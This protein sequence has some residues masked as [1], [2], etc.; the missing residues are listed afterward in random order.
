MKLSALSVSETLRA[1]FFSSSFSSL[2]FKCLE[3]TNFPSLPKKGELLM[4][5]CIFIVGSS[6]LV[7]G[8]A[9]G[10]SKSAI[11]SPIL[12]P[13]IPTTAQMSPARTSVTFFFPSPSKIYSSFTL[14]FTTLPSSFIKE[15]GWLSLITPLAI[16]PTAILPKKEE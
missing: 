10:S 14:L 7:T 5:N 9:S 6:T 4:L 2:S 15:I 8:N 12:N 11:V 16:L 13:S 3:V 1:R